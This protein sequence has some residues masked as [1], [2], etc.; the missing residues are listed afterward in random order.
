[1]PA[2][3]SSVK[4][5]LYSIQTVYNLFWDD[6]GTIPLLRC[7]NVIEVP[8]SEP[9]SRIF[10]G[11][12]DTVIPA[13]VIVIE[14]DSDAYPLLGRLSIAIETNEGVT[15]EPIAVHAPLTVY[16]TAYLLTM[17]RGTTG[18]KNVSI[19]IADEVVPNDLAFEVMETPY[20]YENHLFALAF[21]QIAKSYNQLVSRISELEDRV[22]ALE[23]KN[24]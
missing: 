8:I 19:T 23:N 18:I 22:T 14:N 1:M 20:N 21:H 5:T 10:Q 4:Q 2:P 11:V 3:P 9:V 12:K 7:K 15:V 16:T 13:T 6:H 17:P 24:T